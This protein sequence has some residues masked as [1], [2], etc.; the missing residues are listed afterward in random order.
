MVERYFPTSSAAPPVSKSKSSRRLRLHLAISS[1]NQTNI[2]M[3][4]ANKRK[5]LSEHIITNSDD[6]ADFESTNDSAGDEDV[7]REEK[8]AKKKAKP[9]TA[10][11]S[12]NGE[13]FSIDL[14]GKKKLSVQ[15]VW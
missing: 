3:S 10:K 12:G 14:G 15:K 11:D 8:P 9:E 5:K 2:D 7:E 1:P 13:E 4:K 6:E